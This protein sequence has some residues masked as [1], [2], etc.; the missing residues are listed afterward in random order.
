MLRSNQVQFTLLFNIP[1]YCFFKLGY[2]LSFWT[3]K[4]IC[5]LFATCSSSCNNSHFLSCMWTKYEQK[6]STT[7]FYIIFL[8]RGITTLLFAFNFSQ[9]CHRR[10]ERRT[11]IEIGFEKLQIAS[12]I[13][14]GECHYLFNHHLKS[15]ILLICR[16]I[17]LDF[18]REL[19][20]NIG[21]LPDNN[22]IYQKKNFYNSPYSVKIVSEK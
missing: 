17:F 3:T 7:V 10:I 12:T 16:V 9:Y 4:T 21:L 14:L 19:R 8:N 11:I 6:D 5:I 15:L 18:S 1:V 13:K 20:G 22:Y 2:V